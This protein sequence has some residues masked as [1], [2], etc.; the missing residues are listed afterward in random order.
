MPICIAQ[1]IR[2]QKYLLT[3][4][5]YALDLCMYA[6]NLETYEFILQRYNQLVDVYLFFP[7][8]I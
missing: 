7:Q 3:T 1:Q 8:D 6:G 5:R 2:I 4:F